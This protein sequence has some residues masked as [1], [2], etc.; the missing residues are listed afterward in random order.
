MEGHGRGCSL[1]VA[2][3]YCFQDREVLI[4]NKLKT[5]CRLNQT[6]APHDPHAHA[7]LIRK[8]FDGLPEERVARR[9]GHGVVELEVR[10]H[11]QLTSTDDLL[12][13]LQRQYDVRQTLR[14]VSV[15]GKRSGAGLQRGSELQAGLY[16]RYA[17]YRSKPKQGPMRAALDVGA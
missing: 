8:H 13:P 3:P 9:S 5:L 2:R 12:K 11:T 7:D 1:P 14:I 4:L 15:G 10:V 16:S 6:E 17:S